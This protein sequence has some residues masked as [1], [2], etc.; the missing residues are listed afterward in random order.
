M[1]VFRY[2]NI[3]EVEIAPSVFSLSQNY[4]NPFNPVTIIKYQL[5]ISNFVS[6]NLYDVLGNEVVTLV[7]EE[8]PAGEYE[9]EFDGSRL[10]SGIYFYKLLSGSFVETKKMILLK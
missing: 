6:I 2:S 3:I 8:Q 4:P 1:A 9:I 5:P 10:P 7:N